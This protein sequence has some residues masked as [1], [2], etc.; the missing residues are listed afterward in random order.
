[1]IVMSCC[2]VVMSF[3]RDSSYKKSATRQLDNEQIKSGSC[4]NEIPL[5]PSAC[6]TFSLIYIMQSFHATPLFSTFQRKYQ[7]MCFS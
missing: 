2:H 7:K 1:M 4:F 3:V 6:S 5:I